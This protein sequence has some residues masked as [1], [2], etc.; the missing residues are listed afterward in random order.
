MVTA[1]CFKKFTSTQRRTNNC[2]F[3]GARRDRTAD[4]LNAIQALSQLSYGPLGISYS[5][6]ADKH[7]YLILREVD[8]KENARRRPHS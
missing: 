4:L 7:C 5:E 1:W 6:Y 3:G 2:Q 8:G